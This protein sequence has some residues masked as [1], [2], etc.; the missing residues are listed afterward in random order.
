MSRRS[1]SRTGIAELCLALS[2][3]LGRAQEQTTTVPST[4]Q[5]QV[6]RIA[7]EVRK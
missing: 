5:Q 4:D 1:A 2:V 6:L 3:C 7:K